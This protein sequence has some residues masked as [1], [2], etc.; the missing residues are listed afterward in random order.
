MDLPSIKSAKRVGAADA[1]LRRAA[2]LIGEDVPPR[3][4]SGRP[5]L[6]VLRECLDGQAVVVDRFNQL[7]T[8]GCSLSV[9][10]G[11]WRDLMRASEF[12]G[13]TARIEECES[14]F[15]AALSVSVAGRRNQRNGEE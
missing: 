6:E 3:D 1:C 12:L 13:L 8:L 10:G 4:N 15:Q 2:L 5:T 14:R 11:F 9:P 7:F